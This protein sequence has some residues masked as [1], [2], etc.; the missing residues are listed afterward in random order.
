MKARVVEKAATWQSAKPEVW[1]LGV[2][3]SWVDHMGSET[4]TAQIVILSWIIYSRL[5][6]H[7][8]CARVLHLE[9]VG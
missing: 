1:E 9:P 8:G 6:R 2:P 3:S 7:R 5:P 4:A